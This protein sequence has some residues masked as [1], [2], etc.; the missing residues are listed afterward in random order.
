MAR[1]LH[2]G[3]IHGFR[4]GRSA[5]FSRR[6]TAMWSLRA[7]RCAMFYK[8]ASTTSYET[9]RHGAV[10]AER[11]ATEGRGRH[12]VLPAARNPRRVTLMVATDLSPCHFASYVW[13]NRA[14]P[15]VKF[16]IWLL[17]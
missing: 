8:G 4:R 9:G 10:D 17:V 12:P 7:P 5:T 2:S 15:R 16:F 1:A 3:K 11:H 14:P 13:K 6:S